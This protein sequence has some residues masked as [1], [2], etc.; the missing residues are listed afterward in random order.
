MMCLHVSLR[1]VEREE[2]TMKLGTH[3]V[4][5]GVSLYGLQR[6]IHYDT[7]HMECDYMWLLRWLTKE[8]TQY[9]TGHM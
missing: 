4:F 5:A 6:R 3:V 8:D 2:H 1:M 9:Y 7:A